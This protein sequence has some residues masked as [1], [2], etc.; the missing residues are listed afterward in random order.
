VGADTLTS[1]TV[2]LS[3]VSISASESGTDT[4]AAIAVREP[5]AGATTLLASELG[6]DAASA[7]ATT[8][9]RAATS[10]TE[11]VGDTASALAVSRLTASATLVELG[12]DTASTDA[13]SQPGAQAQAACAETGADT[14]SA[15]IATGLTTYIAT[16]ESAR[17]GASAQVTAF[18]SASVAAAEAGL[19]TL[20]SAAAVLDDPRV[21][22]ALAATESGADALAAGVTLVAGATAAI[23]EGFGLS[24]RHAALLEGL[25]RIHGL[26]APLSVSR[27]ARSDGTLVQSVSQVGDQVTVTTTSGPTG[28]EGPS[29]LNATQAEWL[30]LLALAHGLTAPLVVTPTGRA[31]GSLNQTI[32]QVDDVVTV[33]RA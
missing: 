31:A 17:D 21:F 33:S 27:E 2:A 8:P 18:I 32:S 9:V 1:S 30:E 22:A 10:T 23:S 19:D 15:Q 3:Q 5:D 26:I 16:T 7:A 24:A 4:L 20:S 25:A 6:G 12:S 28:A 13:V 11:T 14:S 29:V